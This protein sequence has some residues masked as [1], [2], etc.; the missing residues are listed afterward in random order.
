VGIYVG[1]LGTI[2]T[3]VEAFTVVAQ[4]VAF[5]VTL[6]FARLLGLR[7]GRAIFYAIVTLFW[8]LDILLFLNSMDRARQ[9]RRAAERPAAEVV[10]VSHEPE[11][12]SRESMPAP[13]WLRPKN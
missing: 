5:I 1:L 2:V 4:L 7:I 3:R 11:L 8:F 13:E 6:W 10:T 9:S 12:P